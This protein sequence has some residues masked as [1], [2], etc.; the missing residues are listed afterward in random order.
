MTGQLLYVTM[1]YRNLLAKPIPFL[2]RA[3]RHVPHKR[4]GN[5]VPR[6]AAPRINSV[7]FRNRSGPT[8][9]GNAGRSLMRKSAQEI[10]HQ[11][12]GQLWSDWLV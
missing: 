8:D 2:K 5:V 6:C 9:H 1:L 3:E 12:V 11:G 4:Q 10:I 7:E